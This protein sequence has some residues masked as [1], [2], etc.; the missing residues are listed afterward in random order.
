MRRRLEGWRAIWRAMGAVA[1]V[2]ALWWASAGAARAVVLAGQYTVS[3]S[4]TQ[5]GANDYQF[6]YQ[7]TNNNQASTT[8]TGLDGFYVQVPTAAVISNVT[9]PESASRSESDAAMSLNRFA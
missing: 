7:V 9:V 5:L 1:C 8:Q 3:A 4:Y 2:A 6:T